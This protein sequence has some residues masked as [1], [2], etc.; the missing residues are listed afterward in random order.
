[1]AREQRRLAAI[2]AADVV[3][4]SRLM[5]RDES[6][7]LA[8]LKAHRSERLEPALARNG[9][10]LVK[11][12]G[13]GALA[14]FGSAVDALRAAIEFQQAVAEANHDQPEE[15][16]IVFRIGLHLGDLIVDGDDLYGDGVNV[17]ARLEAEAPPGG[18]VV[19]RDVHNAVTG[20]L[21]ATLHDLG[22]LPLKNIERPVQA[23]RAEWRPED[24][25]AHTVASPQESRAP[26]SPK[27]SEP[28]LALPDKPSIAVLP[29]QN[30]SG[31]PEQEYFADGMVE[32]I[33]TA[34]SRFKSLFVIARNSSFSYK[35]KSPDVRQVGRELGV[36]YVLEGSV[37]KAGGKVR[38]TGQLI[39]AASGAHLWADRFDGA[40]EDVFNLQDEVT[41]K[42]IAA[43]APGVEKVE[44]ERAL[45]KPT[46]SLDAHDCYLRAL[47]LWWRVNLERSDEA[48]RLL[49]RAL[50]IDPAHSSSMGLL[51][52]AYA[53]R[54][55][56]G[57]GGDVATDIAE[58]DR[59][60]RQA[61]HIGRD[62]AATLGHT[63]WA[64]AV[65][66]RDLSFAR[67]Q[68]QRALTLNPNLASAW[69]F[70]GWLHLW[71]GKPAEALADLSHA[72]R[73]DPLNESGSWKSAL[74]HAYFF[75]D[76]HEDALRAAESMMQSNPDAH[77]ALR[78]GA[79]SAAFAGKTEVAQKY[80]LRLASVDAALRVS[81]LENYLGPYPAEFCEKY[82]QGLRT[83]GLPE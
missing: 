3:G 13:D 53:T 45:R 36:R 35:G 20:K 82:K 43:I 15:T 16:R 70:S 52:G 57:I 69:F 62:D 34:L 1:M 71:S 7:T 26:V 28:T 55:T 23:F 47:P 22:E 51:L 33:I 8:R 73:L 37:R 54:K 61:V 78:I 2:L 6:G 59:L 19:S 17:A 27:E 38:I 48:V 75:L 32:D 79:A 74:A 39:E 25:P 46:A 49:R 67:E 41:E 81:R 80:A 58:V 83:A 56:A 64:I 21:K 50:K 12:T 18:V 14:E 4:F 31:D 30:M 77:A 11:L 40:I 10:R 42:V 63:A 72:A 5:G 44:I 29:F 66:L 76:R 9:G 24:W 60:I 65:L 68:S